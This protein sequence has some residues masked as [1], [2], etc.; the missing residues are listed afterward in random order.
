MKLLIVNFDFPPN[1]GIGGRRWAKLAKGLARE[2]HQVWVIKADPLPAKTKSQWINDVQDP[3]IHV[4]SLPRAYP[5][6]LQSP[7]LSVIDKVKYH[8]AK[9]RLERQEKGSIYDLSIGWSKVMLAEVEKICRAEKIQWILA[10]GAPWNMLYDLAVWRR[11]QEQ[12]KLMVDFRDPWVSARN[13][14]MAGLTPARKAYEVSK[15]QRVLEWS[16]L[17]ISP[18]PHLTN[19]LQNSAPQSHAKFH[20]L[21]HFYDASD[22]VDLKSVSYTPLTFAYA[23]EMYVECEPQLH[24]L[25]EMLHKM[26]ECDNDIYQRIQF[27]FYTPTNRKSFFEDH[28]QV[29]FFEPLGKEIFQTLAT[30]NSLMLLLTQSKRNDLTTK[31]FEYLPLQRPLIAWGESGEVSK[32]VTQHKLGGHWDSIMPYAQ[33]LAH[34]KEIEGQAAT[35]NFA[36]EQYE[37]Q[38]ITNQLMDLLQ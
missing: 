29:H 18:Y 17:V 12:S 10:T 36:F 6:S 30:A 23:G 34:I 38:T 31:F 7:V 21:S 22:F 3:S 26:R 14:G 27:H 37:L 13:Y 32:F 9:W 28:P 2:G 16:D 19:E 33:W 15:Q 5:T 35:S 1:S 8:W 25:N 24:W 4:I 11:T 20:V